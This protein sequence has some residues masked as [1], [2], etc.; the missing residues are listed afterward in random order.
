MPIL[1]L[2]HCLNISEQWLALLVLLR[3]ALVQLGNSFDQLAVYFVFF[4]HLLLQY[5]HFPLHLRA[6]LANSILLI[7][8]NLCFSLC[9][10][11]GCELLF[12][13]FFVLEEL[14]SQLA[15]HLVIVLGDLVELRLSHFVSVLDLQSLVTIRLALFKLL[16]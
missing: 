11:D 7:L 3:Q 13:V 12:E 16:L 1:G 9:N 8:G 10:F 4:A 15:H 14:I 5:V 2:F 6:I